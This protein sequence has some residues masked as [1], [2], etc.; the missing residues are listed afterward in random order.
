MLSKTVVLESELVA[1]FPALLY[2]LYK[3]ISRDAVDGSNKGY[4]ST[5]LCQFTD[6]DTL[7]V[8]STCE[9][10]VLSG[11]IDDLFG[12]CHIRNESGSLANV[13]FSQDRVQNNNTTTKPILQEIV[14]GRM[15]VPNE[16]HLSVTC[17]EGDA[18]Q[19]LR[20][21][22]PMFYI[23]ITKHNWQLGPQEFIVNIYP[24][25]QSESRPS[26]EVRMMYGQN[27]SRYGDFIGPPA[28][29]FGTGSLISEAEWQDTPAKPVKNGLFDTCRPTIQHQQFQSPE[30]MGRNTILNST[31][32]SFS[33]D[34][35]LWF[36]G[37]AL[38]DK[39]GFLNGTETKCSLFPCVQQVA[40]VK[41]QN[42]QYTTQNIR[43]NKR[44]YY[45]NTTE[46]QGQNGSY[47]ELS[48][49]F[50]SGDDDACRFSWTRDAV[51]FLGAWLNSTIDTSAFYSMYMN[52]TNS[53]GNDYT[54][55]YERVAAQLSAVLQSQ[56]NPDVANITGVA[57]GAEIYVQ[58]NW[59]WFIL[60]LALLASCL[61]I[62]VLSI[63][64][65]SR[66]SYLFKNNIL[67]AIAFEL[68]GWEPPE[69]GVDET[70]T[71]HSMRNVEKKAER[72][73]AGMQ[74]PHEGDGG[75]RLKRE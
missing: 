65:S 11:S 68:H 23:N 36:R 58:V 38:S 46:V 10:R 49:P 53:P 59:L 41:L 64:D 33:T 75:L 34:L 39:F 51:Q 66:K 24:L 4:C 74:L 43:Q 37:V 54:L 60:P 15:E 22:P 73:V 21:E 6:F 12:G 1:V 31:C 13:G 8:C 70:W 35:A 20:E 30:R 52:Q 32:L 63:W 56:A 7:A 26:A 47:F 40:G 72:M 69:Y 25:G 57:Y 61:L 19:E 44:W 16:W 67:A 14:E 45:S 48:G 5:S 42:N 2:G 71:R 50:C 17:G 3:A 27:I 9:K 28:Y 62:V 18:L 55:F 29:L